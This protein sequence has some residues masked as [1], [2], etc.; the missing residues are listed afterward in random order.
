MTP[1]EAIAVLLDADSDTTDMRGDRYFGTMQLI[2]EGTVLPYQVC[3][4]ITT[5]FNHHL[6][7]NGGIASRS[8]QL[9]HFGF[10]EAQVVTLA[11]A[12][13]K[14]L[15]AFRGV[16]SDTGATDLTIRSL[17]IQD[18]ASGQTVP[19]AAQASG[20]SRIRQEYLM[21]FLLA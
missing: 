16:V 19:D 7:G 18:E 9:D 12:A 5:G 6:T 21:T 8:L 14:K 1:S 4:E 2:E 11:D 15:D 13:R 17:R 20:V 3:S 10:T